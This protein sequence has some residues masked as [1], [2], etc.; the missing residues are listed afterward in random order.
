MWRPDCSR[1][2]STHQAWRRHPMIRTIQ[3]GLFTI[4]QDEG[5]WGYQAYGMPVAGAMDRYAYRAANLLAGNHKGAAVLE[6]TMLG[7]TFQFSSD[8]FVS[9]C[10]AD[11][12]AKVNGTSVPNWSAFPV[13]AG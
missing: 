12:Q 5:R 6:M 8:C 3:P 13:A 2:T 4:I 11:M 9:V 1:L 7:G 10:G